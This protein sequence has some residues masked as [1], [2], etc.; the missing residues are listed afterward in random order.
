M[1]RRDRDMASPVLSYLS[2]SEIEVGLRW[3]SE[4]Y[5]EFADLIPLHEKSGLGKTIHALRL[6][7]GEGERN[8]VLLIGGTHA[9]ELIN[10]DL[11]TFLALRLCG[12][13]SRNTGLVFGG[14]TWSPSDIQLLKGGVDIFIAPNINPDGREHVESDYEEN[15]DWKKNRRR[16]DDGSCGTDLNRNFDFLWDCEIGSSTDGTSQNYRGDRAFSEPE[17]RN[18]RWL[19][20]QYPHITCVAD[21]HSYHEGILHPWGDADNQSVDPSKSFENPE[22]DHRRGLSA[23]GEYIPAED[24]AE[25][26]RRGHEMRDAIA[27]VRG[28]SYE[29]GQSYDVIGYYT[30]GTVK[31]YAYSRFFRG[32]VAKVWAYTIETNREGVRGDRDQREQDGYA[33]A[34]TEAL[35]VMREVQSGLIQFM[36]SCLCVVREIGRGPLGPEILEELSHFRDEEMLTTRRGRGWANIL[37]A[38]GGELLR[39]LAGD[40]RAREEAEQLLVEGARVVL[41]RGDER[42]PVIDPKVTASV[43]RLAARLEASASPNLRRALTSIRKDAKAVSGKTVRE[44]IGRPPPRE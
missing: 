9:K 33:P 30:A 5:P 43:D 10:P 19:L 38:N 37:D 32:P 16:N 40:V 18:I 34:Y 20:N 11:L 6:R 22:W 7:Y 1:L 29:V 26:I 13:Y 12:A 44:A 41:G 25:F 21:V 36:L 24:E 35:E 14:K 31:D 2:T 3:M 15:W 42:P 23:Y 17:S 27:A 39:L 4:V 28:R 8:G